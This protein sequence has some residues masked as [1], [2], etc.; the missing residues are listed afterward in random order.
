MTASLLCG[1]WLVVRLIQSVHRARKAEAEVRR[2]NDR[3]EHLVAERT[4]ALADTEVQLRNAISTA[5]DG[6]VA[7]DAGGRLFLANEVAREFLPATNVHMI[8]GTALAEVIRSTQ[9]F[10]DPAVVASNPGVHT[11]EV[12][13]PPGTWTRVTVR[14]VPDGTAVMRLADISAYKQATRTL[15]R[16][17]LR[18]QNLRQLYRDF[19]AVVS[20]QFRTPLAI[21]DSGAQKILRRGAGAAW[22][23]IADRAQQIR[24]AA[25]GLVA[26]VDGTLDGAGLDHGEIAFS[27][28]DVNLRHFLLDLGGRLQDVYQRR[29]L[30]LEVGELPALVRC[31]PLLLEHVIGNLVSNSAKYSGDGA[32]V[33]IIA[34]ASSDAV[35]IVVCD[36]GVGIPHEELDS[37]FE[38]SYRARNAKERA[39]SGVGLHFVRQ[40][41]RLHGGEIRVVSTIGAGT[42]VTLDLPIEGPPPRLAA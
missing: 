10:A 4:L 33:S 6:F 37:V 16:A 38:L 18:E 30:N 41:V 14:Q 32:P 42:T 15:E 8:A 5:P 28:Q 22:S 12:E 40:I 31:D 39:G 24:T 3:L 17:V 7:F 34:E 9:A 21:I 27:P 25:S 26:L 23:D 1:A 35:S 36:Q 11:A 19:V 29:R 20:H 13:G 2:H